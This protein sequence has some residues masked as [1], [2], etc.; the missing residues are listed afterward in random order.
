MIISS[1]IVTH[2]LLFFVGMLSRDL[3]VEGMETGTN[4]GSRFF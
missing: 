1:F 2:L 4:G 3:L